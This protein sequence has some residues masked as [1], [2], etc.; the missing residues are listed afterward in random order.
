M[1]DGA[2]AIARIAASLDEDPRV[3]AIRPIHT[4]GFD[5][6]AS[7][8]GPA[9]SQALSALKSIAARQAVALTDLY[10]SLLRKRI[11]RGGPGAGSAPFTAPRT[12][13]NAPL[14]TGRSIATLSLPLDEMKAVGKA[15]GGTI[16][17]VAL[18]IVDAALHRYL[19]DRLAQHTREAFAALRRAVA[20]RRPTS[21]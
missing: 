8:V 15:F 17:D 1:V 19:D 10:R 3:R 13:T 18:T 5:A 20:R 11:G 6:P 16:N 12:P 14:R 21:A 2:S 9:R 7:S 4:I